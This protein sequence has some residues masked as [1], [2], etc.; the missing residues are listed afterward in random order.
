MA[1]SLAEV[2]SVLDL[3][4]SSVQNPIPKIFLCGGP[5]LGKG[6]VPRS[7]R[8]LLIKH[9]KR[10]KG[11]LPSYIVLAEELAEWYRIIG[12][13]D[14][15]DLV[16]FETQIADLSTMILLIVESPGSMAELGAFSYA[17]RLL[18]KLHVI[19]ETT[20]QEDRSFIIDGPVAMVRSSAKSEKDSKRFFTYRWMSESGARRI[21]FDGASSSATKVLADI[22]EP[23]VKTV[24]SPKRFRKKEVGHQMLLI[25]DLVSLCGAVRL[26]EILELL[27]GVKVKITRKRVEQYLGLLRNM[28]FLVLWHEGGEDYFVQ[29]DTSLRFMN[30]AVSDERKSGSGDRKP[31]FDRARLRTYIL[32]SLQEGADPQNREDAFNAVKGRAKR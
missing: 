31:K 19:L 2:V 17:D 11:S 15:T 22:I 12:P 16:D 7:F 30:Y 28:K 14:F 23:A 1:R 8:A 5:L 25:A 32:Q 29:T 27:A 6:R 13:K 10:G 24:N 9:L 20:H 4:E 21:D 18:R 26:E 3:S